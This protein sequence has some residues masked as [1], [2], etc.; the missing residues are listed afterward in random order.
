ME[1]VTYTRKEMPAIAM[2]WDP[3]SISKI[4]QK[5]VDCCIPMAMDGI[6]GVRWSNNSDISENV[7]ADIVP[8]TSGFVLVAFS[9]EGREMPEL[10]QEV[11]N[12]LMGMGITITDH[13]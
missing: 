7:L 6:R 2:S 13:Y 5:P 11:K 10:E 8:L 1:K 3:Q 12:T 4:L 9:K